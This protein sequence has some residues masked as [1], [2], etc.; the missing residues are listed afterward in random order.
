MPR[1]TSVAK[2]QKSPGKCGKCGKEIKAGEQYK[3]WAFRYGGKHVRCATCPMPRPS[4]LTQSKMSGVYAAQENAQDAIYAFR[5]GSHDTADDLT[6]ALESAAE[7][8]RSVAEEY[9]ESQQNIEDGFNHSTCQSDELGE[10][11]DTLESSADELES[12][13]SD[14]EDF[15]AEN[16]EGVDDEDL[17][18]ELE[19]PGHG[20]DHDDPKARLAFFEKHRAALNKAKAEKVEEARQE[21]ANEQAD[22]AEDAINNI[23]MP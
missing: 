19:L 14:F 8:I 13:S 16:V 3:W 20:D 18:Q 7:D 17:A 10:K 4:E 2:A 15:D 23:E 21:W 6:S 22:K 12:A 11:A 1:V 5:D 9:R